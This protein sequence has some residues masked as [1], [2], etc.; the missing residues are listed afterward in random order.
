MKGRSA[1]ETPADLVNRLEQP[2]AVWVMVPAGGPTGQVVSEPCRVG[3]LA[4]GDTV[5][6]GGN[7]YYRD[8]IA[9]AATLAENDLHY[10]DVGTSGG[11]WGRD[12]GYCLMIGG[13][14]P[15]G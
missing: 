4:A 9:R 15:T 12:R 14:A 8:D 13:D 1:S 7:S 2:R 6:D 3:L 10:L 11:V 5:I